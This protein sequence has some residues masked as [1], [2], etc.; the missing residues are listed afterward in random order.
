MTSQTREMSVNRA[1]FLAG[2]AIFLTLMACPLLASAKCPKVVDPEQMSMNSDTIVYGKVVSLNALEGDRWHAEVEVHTSYK[3]KHKPDDTVDVYT[4]GYTD[5]DFRLEQSVMVYANKGSGGKLETP[6]CA[7]PKSLPEAPLA[8]ETSSLFATPP[9]KAPLEIRARRAS[10]IFV[11]EVTAAGK[12]FAGRWDGVILKVKVIDAIKGT[13]RNATV[14]IRLDEDSCGGGKRRNLLSDGDMLAGDAKAPYEVKKTYLF[15]TFDES[16][17]QVLL[18]HDNMQPKAAASE[19]ISMLKTMCKKKRCQSGHDVVG[20]LRLGVKQSVE[21]KSMASLKQCA[22]ELPLYTKSG[23]ITDLEVKVRVR[24]DGVT[25]LLNV[26][27]SGTVE[28]GSVYDALGK[29]MERQI[30]QWDFEAK[31]GRPDLEAG[32]TLRMKESSRGPKYEDVS[33]LLSGR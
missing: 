19:D 11:G 2:V 29:C 28:D 25:E 22:A 27:S 21:K 8:A 3:G 31:E 14:K 5:I 4:A 13:K 18:C 23:A 10:A 16:P 7:N 6:K 20:K 33:V 26:A 32:V 17:Y 1:T 9:G 12:G 30:V 15:Y 24:P